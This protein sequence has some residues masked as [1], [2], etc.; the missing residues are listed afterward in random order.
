[1][2]KKLQMQDLQVKSF[3]TNDKKA[4]IEGGILL[5]GTDEYRCSYFC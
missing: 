5:W 3:L 2:K 4:E 1:M